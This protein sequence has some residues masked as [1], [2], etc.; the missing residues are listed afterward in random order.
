MSGVS[1]ERWLALADRRL[2]EAGYRSGSA[3]SAVIELMAREG[4]CVLSAQDIVGRLRQAGVGSAATVY[5]AL[6][7]L[8]ELGLVHR[9]DGR[10]GVARYEI[11]D[12]DGHHHHFVDE[13]TGEVWPFEDE[14]LER[15][16][17]SVAERLGVRLLAHDVTLRGTAREDTPGAPGA[18]T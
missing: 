12:P 15:V 5:R 10:D 13:R 8:H 14:E 2:R 4:H 18:T 11:A 1:A 17:G 7:T 16:I 9:V 3:R 6:E